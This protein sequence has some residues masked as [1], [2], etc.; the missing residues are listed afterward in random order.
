MTAFALLAALAITSFDIWK[1]RL[2]RNWKRLHQVVYLA[3]PIAVLHYA[4]SKKGDLFRLQGDVVR[5]LIYA[6]IVLFLLVLR[7]PWIRRSVVSLRTR[8]Q[9]GLGR[10][11]ESAPTATR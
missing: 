4:L 7:L 11:R 9:V 5:P 3:A 6:L 2:G 1:V 8:I 10:A